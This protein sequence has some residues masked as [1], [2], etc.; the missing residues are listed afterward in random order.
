MKNGNLYYF[1]ICILVFIGFSLKPS[2]LSSRSIFYMSRGFS[3][4]LFKH[5]F[6]ISFLVVVLLIIYSVDLLHKYKPLFPCSVF[7]IW[8]S[9]PTFL[10]WGYLR[11]RIYFSGPISVFSLHNI[12]FFIGM[13][14]NRLRERVGSNPLFWKG[15]KFPLNFHLCFVLMGDYVFIS[16]I[17]MTGCHSPKYL[18]DIQD[19]QM[20]PLYLPIKHL[21]VELHTKL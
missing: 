19:I 18:S 14:E 17:S 16:R 8:T 7:Y 1:E 5:P 9:F 6:L 4:L 15:R 12:N 2:S 3:F 11:I 13:I 10:L 21:I 20:G